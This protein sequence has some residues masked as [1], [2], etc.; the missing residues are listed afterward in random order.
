M[1]FLQKNAALIFSSLAVAAWLCIMPAAKA[2]VIVT[3]DFLQE[4]I[5]HYFKETTPLTKPQASLQVEP[6]HLPQSAITLQ[7]DHLKVLMNDSR[8]TPLT[9][10]TV[11]EVTLST[12][13]ETRSIG[14][15]VKLIVEEPVWIVSHLVNARQPIS[16]KDVTVQRKRLEYDG[17][18]AL[19]TDENPTAYTAKVDLPPGSVLDMRKIYLTPAVFRNNQVRVIVTLANG[20]QISFY[21]KALEDGALGKQI[22]ISQVLSNNTKKIYTGQVIDKNTVAVSL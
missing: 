12:E 7:G 5:T 6:V 8:S 9:F 10:R 11:V 15:P 21:G 14:I 17:A 13:R 3:P 1:K 18:Y 22:R 4:K 20:I 16:A 19:D 2:D